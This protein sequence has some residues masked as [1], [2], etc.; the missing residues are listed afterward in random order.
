[1]GI[2]PDLATRYPAELSGGQRPRVAIARALVAKPAV[3]LCDEVTSSLDVSVQASVIELLR[4]LLADGLGMLFVTHDLA[5]V[6]NIADTVAVLSAGRVVEQGEARA[7]LSAPS[8]PYTQ[9]LL[10][11]TL[12]LPTDATG[13]DMPA[14]APRQSATG[15]R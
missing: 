9:S 6:R 2:S 14:I 7:V 5:V 12:Q 3:L 8:H 4:S 11:N 15:S 10:A 1:M 13:F